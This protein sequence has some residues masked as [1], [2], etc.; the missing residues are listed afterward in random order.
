M[1]KTET[2]Y[3]IDFENVN[4]AGLSHSNSLG[5]HD[6]LCIFSTEKA[7]KI[8]IG[9]LGSLNGIDCETY[10]VPAGNQSADM[11][12]IAYLGY[13]I[14]KK[15]SKNHKYIIVSKDKDYDNIIA[16]LKK[17]SSAKIT[18]QPTL[19][20]VSV[21]RKTK[22]NA[23]IQRCISDC[24][25][26]EKKNINRIASIVSKHYGSEHFPRDVHNELQAT[27]TDFDEIYKKIKPIIKRYT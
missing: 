1:P 22:L 25:D 13:L 17:H 21:S 6:H 11:H 4:D 15:G 14:G 27:Y 9:I 3:L 18:R 24:G 23:E 20:S 7:P 16:F 2:Y 8:S 19:D 5:S 12:I 10:T 26:Y